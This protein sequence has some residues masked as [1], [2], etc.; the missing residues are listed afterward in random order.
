M[1]SHTK[2]H[3]DELTTAE[4]DS[5]LERFDLTESSLQ[6]KIIVQFMLKGAEVEEKDAIIGDLAM[7]VRRLSVVVTRVSPQNTIPNQALDYLRRKELLGSPL[8][9]DS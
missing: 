8:R 9:S 6:R 7:L 2:R 3:V 5:L 1:T 4:I